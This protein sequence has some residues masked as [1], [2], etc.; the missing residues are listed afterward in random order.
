MRMK[1]QPLRPQTL[2]YAIVD[3]QVWPCLKE[4]RPKTTVHTGE[5]LLPKDV[6]YHL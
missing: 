5:A 2:I 1:R 6:T 4:R 3:R